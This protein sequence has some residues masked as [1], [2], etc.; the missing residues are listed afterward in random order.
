MSER[1]TCPMP[2]PHQDSSSPTWSTCYRCGKAEGPGPTPET[3]RARDARMAELRAALPS[4]A[5]KEEP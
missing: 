5:A 1:C 4:S 3:L 2:D